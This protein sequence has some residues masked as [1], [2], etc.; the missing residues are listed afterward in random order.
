M[1]KLVV[2]NKK[3]M[4]NSITCRNSCD[5]FDEKT[6]SCSIHQ[7]VNVDSAYDAARCGFFLNKNMTVPAPMTNRQFKYSLI[8]EEE[9]YLL[10][11]EEVFEIVGKKVYKETYLY[12][13]EPD[14]SAFRDD[15]V[16][17]VSTCGSFGCWIVNHCKRLM[18]CP[19]NIDQAEKGWGRNVYKSP[20]P[21][22]DHKTSISLASKVVWY[23]D[24]EGYGQYGL[25]IN[26]QI[27][28]LSTPR[29]KTW[30]KGY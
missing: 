30:Q 20:F 5:Y 13:K 15:A 11:D 24:E 9:E 3:P 16:W 8:E 10:D 7:N 18:V 6:A 21:L 26:G 17:F 29:P 12:P 19:K 1:L 14:Y 2:D 23:I 27:S 25:L 4:E 22:H 28:S